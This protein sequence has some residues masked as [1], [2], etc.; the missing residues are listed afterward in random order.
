MPEQLVWGEDETKLF[1]A[2]LKTQDINVLRPLLAK[3]KQ[4]NAFHLWKEVK[5]SEVLLEGPL[6]IIPRQ[7]H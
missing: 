1:E 4:P 2:I 6:L 3:L 7:V 5:T